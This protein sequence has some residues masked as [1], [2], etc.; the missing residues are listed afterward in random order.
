[1]DIRKAAHGRARCVKTGSFGNSGKDGGKGVVGRGQRVVGKGQ[2]GDCPIPPRWPFGQPCY[3]QLLSG[4]AF[5]MPSE[6]GRVN[7]KGGS[8]TWLKPL[9]GLPDPSSSTC[10]LHS[11]RPAPSMHRAASSLGQKGS[12]CSFFFFFLMHSGMT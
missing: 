9:A 7:I 4:C 12:I 5:P 2:G 1:M 11:V 3:C 10:P 8:R 6:A